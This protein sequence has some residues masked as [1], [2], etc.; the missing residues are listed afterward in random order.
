MDGYII[1]YKKPKHNSKLRKKNSYL[2]IQKRIYYKLGNIVLTIYL[3]S[4]LFIIKTFFC[5]KINKRKLQENK[6]ISKY[7]IDKKASVQLINNQVDISSMTSLI[8][9]SNSITPVKKATLEGGE[10]I[11]ELIFGQPLKDCTK[12]FSGVNKLIYVDFSN[13]DTSKCSNFSMMFKD[14]TA[15][16]SLKFGNIDTSNIKDMSSMFDGCGKGNLKVDALNFDTSSVTNMK[17]M[18]AQSKF[19]FLDLSSFDTSNVVNM[20]GVF[21]SSTIVSVDLSSFDTAKVTTMVDMFSS[22]SKL[23]SLEISNFD[24]TNVETCTHLFYMMNGNVK[25]CNNTSSSFSL[26]LKEANEAKIVEDCDNSCFTNTVNKFIAS[27]YSCVQSCQDTDKKYEYDNLCY[28]GSCPKGSEEYP[29]GSFFCIEV[30]DCSKSFYSYDKTECINEVPSGFY[31]NDETKKT[32]D[33]CPDKCLTCNLTSVNND[34]CIQCNTSFDY[35]E[36]ENY[37]PSS[38]KNYV[39]CFNDPPEGY[40][41]DVN[42]FKQCYTSC[43]YCTGEGTS[44]D[45]KCTECKDGYILDLGS[46]CY[47]KC[48]QGQYYYFDDLNVYHCADSCPSDYKLI[49]PIDKCIKDCRDH[50]PF[51]YQYEDTCLE[52]CPELYHAPYDNKICEVA[53]V[54]D[55]YYNY[56]HN[57]CLAEVPEKYFCNDTTAKTIDRCQDKCQLCTLESHNRDLCTLC[58]N[59]NGFYKREDDNQNTDEFMD[60]YSII[61]EGYFIDNVDNLIK[62]CYKTCKNCNS[63]GNN[64]EHLCSEC[65]SDSTKNDTNCYKICNYYYYFDSSYDYFCTT[66]E[67]CPPE[68]SKLII[69]KNECVESCVGQYKF[70]FENKCYTACPNGSYYNFDQTNCID[71]VPIGYYLNDTQTIDKCDSKCKE[72]NLDS[73]QEN[74]C[75][76][77]N[78]ILG[79][80]K[81]EDITGINGYY[82]CFK[83]NQDGYYLDINNSEYKKCYKTCKSCDETGEVREN[84]CTECYLDST[85]NGTNCYKI[86]PFYHY[87]D[88]SG[89]YFCT[90]EKKCPNT[91]SKLIVD[92]YECVEE[93]INEFRFEFDNKCYTGC[94]PGTYYNYTQTGCI[95]TIPIGYYMND[96]MK[97]TIDKCDIKCENECILDENNNNVICKVC[98]NEHNYYKKADGEEINGYYDCY[99]DQVEKYYLDINDKEYKNCFNKCK[100]CNE[101]GDIYNHKC[102]DCFSGF[103][104]NNT[105]CYEI[106]DYYYYFDLD[107]IYHCSDNENC[108]SIAPFKIIDKKACID[109]C[110]NDDTFKYY[111]NNICYK[112]CSKYY[113]YE[114]TGCIEDIPD[115]YYLNDSVAKTIDKCDK[116]CAKCNKESVKLDQCIT[117][118]N[119]ENYYSKEN[120]SLNKGEY[121]NCYNNFIEGY[122]VD[123]K[124]KRYNKCFEKCKN[125]NDKGNITDHKCN[126]CFTGF[127]LNDTNCYEICPYYYYF[128]DEGVY[129]CTEKNKCPNRDYK[130]ILE[131]NKC[132]DD[133]KNDDKYKYSHRK[134]CVESLHVANCKDNTMFVETKTK[135]CTEICDS[136]DF[137]QNYCSL[138][139]NTPINQDFVISMIEESIESGYL[140]DYIEDIIKNIS[141]DFIVMDGDITYHLATLKST[142]SN[143]LIINPISNI[144]SIDLGDCEIK[145]RNEN[146]IDKN[147]PLIVFKID[148]YTD[149]SLVPIIYY[150]IYN[151]NTLKKLD[152]SICENNNMKIYL[153]VKD[154]DESILYIYNTENDYYSDECTPSVEGLGYDLILSDRQNYYINHNLSLCE[155]NCIYKG[156]NTETK[157]SICLCNIKT[158]VFLASEIENKN[159][160]IEQFPNPV[161]DGSSSTNSMKCTST[162]FTKNGII[163]NIALYIYLVLFIISLIMCIQFYRKGYIGLKNQ[164]NSILATKEKK[165]EEEVPKIRNIE[166]YPDKVN[167]KTIDKI[168]KLRTPKNWRI[169]FKDVIAKDD[170]NYQDNYSSNQKSTNKLEIYNFKQRNDSNTNNYYLETEKNISYSDFELNSFTYREAIGVDMRSFKQI[171]FSLIKYYHPILFLFN[172]NKNYNS[173]YIKMSLI[174]FSFSLYYF[175]NSLFI[176]KSLVHKVYEKGNTNNIGLFIPYIIL[177]FIICYTLDKIIRYG[178]L[179]DYSIYKIYTESLY[180]NAKIRAKNVRKLLFVKYIC[181]YLL[182]FASLLIFGYYLAAFGSVYK[183][184][185]YILIKNVI[186][187]YVISL[188]FPFIIIVLPSILRRYAL[189]DA[190]RQCIFNLS[191]YLQYI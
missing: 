130:I 6:I 118:N 1:N 138:R 7:K 49:A 183:N 76:S 187:S 99:I 142:K 125:C 68:R 42:K 65:N 106:C 160:F 150:E 35:Y 46:N 127:T 177:S 167:Q 108:P 96:S 95:D 38:L 53:L 132:I 5:E 143:N 141:D 57:D 45:N 184:T 146:N 152:L 149:Y 180:N 85:L 14:C 12:I 176:T 87:F 136:D 111:F 23:I 133:C 69:E 129:K 161:S 25:F 55:N 63:L 162:L 155:K 151:P 107:K 27:D 147:I 20:E 134:Y 28:S 140:E 67:E 52:E 70:E 10:S 3:I 131:K 123:Q 80:Y 91:K 166:D 61:P 54:C 9:N 19:Q 60:C 169:D 72:C 30:L 93:C 120:D 15:L 145:L 128:N 112:S 82:D 154:I 74:I 86:C 178:A 172:K 157:K 100:L 105:N 114:Q 144:S 84:K 182:G 158:D 103:T 109:N 44:D 153:P 190:T 110:F 2:N 48:P 64:I 173:I 164:I 66:D 40:F 175:V 33:K 77:C 47:N 137:L 101:L 115:G 71:S 170:I 117:C 73:T 98:N 126:E 181:F 36:A 11:A 121:V 31:C 58:N 34:L 97:R 41:F 83:G 163:K 78:N 32:I 24:L 124:D 29:E 113:N 135:Q 116:K 50:P 56:Y 139:N 51:I 89:E 8:I 79:F 18:F 191:R 171:Y 92:T 43:K 13:F 159:Y 156:Y 185:Q 21:T 102:T 75:T 39:G 179:S 62:K 88:D 90:E 174:L 81:K 122:Y 22:C 37:S 16:T 4:L 17:R 59:E 94:P 148:Y 189:K 119:Q 165:T 26:L 168:L 104:L 186:I 188:V